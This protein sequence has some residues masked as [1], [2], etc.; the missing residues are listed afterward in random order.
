MS[1][2]RLFLTASGFII[3]R[4]VCNTASD[5]AM[6]S[7]KQ[8]PKQ[9]VQQSSDSR[10]RFLVTRVV[11]LVR[12]EGVERTRHNTDYY[13]SIDFSV[14][15]SAACSCREGRT[16]RPWYQNA[17]K[18]ADNRY[19]LPAAPRRHEIHLWKGGHSGLWRSARIRRDCGL[20]DDRPQQAVWKGLTTQPRILLHSPTRP[21]PLA[22][23]CCT[24]HGPLRGVNRT[25]RRDIARPQGRE[26]SQRRG[27]EVSPLYGPAAPASL[28]HTL[29]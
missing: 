19:R 25:S 13:Q 21:P 26:T 6:A 10:L 24:A 29:R 22:A 20:R 11:W 18:R 17:R 4:V 16:P 9:T 5:S 12:T 1:A 23:I 14:S 2:T 15:T 8:A 27:Q 3:Q 7:S 28:S